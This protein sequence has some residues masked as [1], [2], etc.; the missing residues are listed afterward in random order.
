MLGDDPRANLPGRIVTDMLRMTALEVRNPVLL[1]VLVKINDSTKHQRVV[2][3]EPGPGL[4][5]MYVELA[6]SAVLNPNCS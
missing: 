5:S 6:G 3:C 4:I 2:G 1:F